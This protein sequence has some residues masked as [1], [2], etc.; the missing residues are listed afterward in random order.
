MLS[1]RKKNALGVGMYLQGLISQINLSAK[2]EYAL[3]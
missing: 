2:L 1:E 3:A